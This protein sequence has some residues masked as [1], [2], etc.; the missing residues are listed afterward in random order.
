[1]L[2]ERYRH[3]Y[4]GEFVILKTQYRDGRKTQEREW[5]A[6]PIT[7]QHISGRAAC[8]GSSVDHGRFDYTRLQRHR[9]GLR[10]SKRLQTYGCDDIWQQMRLNFYITSDPARLAE[11]AATNY[12][13][14][15]VCYSNARGV[16]AFPG[17]Y[18]L[19]PYSPSIPDPAM[20]VYLAC[21]DGHSEVY[22]L[23]Y[24]Q[25]TPGDPRPWQRA[26]LEIMQV[27]NK[28]DFYVICTP[29]VVPE[30]WLGQPNCHNLVYRDFVSRCDV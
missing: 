27:Y 1:M 16:L 19:C 24:T 10:A 13:D 7:N 23:G 12:G 26:I 14:D 4:D 9:G 20:A 30:L 22:L 15:T 3:D 11:I 8:I 17:Q 28:V 5:V 2:T 25:E 6:N 29:T 18:F 21:F